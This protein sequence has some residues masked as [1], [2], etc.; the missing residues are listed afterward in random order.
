MF[1][2]G[3]AGDALGHA[4]AKI[5]DA[6]RQQFQG[7][8]AGDDLALAHWHRRQGPHR[9][10]GFAGVGGVVHGQEGLAVM[11]RFLSDDHAIHQN[12]GNFDLARMQAAG[13]G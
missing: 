13:L 1:L 7:G 6:V 2:V 5:D 11:F 12:S 9:G 10:A 4:D 8:A 3:H